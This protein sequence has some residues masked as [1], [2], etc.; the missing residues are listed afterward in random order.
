MQYRLFNMKEVEELQERLKLYE[1]MFQD[2]YE[3]EAF[4]DYLLMKNEVHALK[5]QIVKIEGVLKVVNEHQQEQDQKLKAQRSGQSEE[6]KAI[7]QLLQEVKTELASIKGEHDSATEQP[8]EEEQAENVEQIEDSSPEEHVQIPSNQV[9]SQTSRFLQNAKQTQVKKTNNETAQ[10]KR[11][12]QPRRQRT[13]E[14]RQLQ[15]LIRSN[16]TSYVQPDQTSQN[17]QSVASP[18]FKTRVSSGR[19]TT[20]SGN[21]SHT[22]RPRNYP[23]KYDQI[24]PRTKRRKRKRSK[25]KQS[26]TDQPKPT[27]QTDLKRHEQS[28]QKRESQPTNAN[29]AQHNNNQL[30]QQSNTQSLQPK[31]PTEK[32]QPNTQESVLE[33]ILPSQFFKNK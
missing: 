27:V 24:Q 16:A 17:T 22:F 29:Q 7:I 4:E 31:Q 23:S 33:K 21:F 10:P 9:N 15:H 25:P 6:L 3:S 26:A 8:T 11:S 14:F 1:N 13:P 18:R 12:T 30:S 32:Q 19:T 2:F 5:K 28:E 20:S